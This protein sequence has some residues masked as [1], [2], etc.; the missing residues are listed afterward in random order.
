[1]VGTV[2]DMDMADELRVTLVATGLG[3]EV[4]MAQRPRVKLVEPEP[5]PQAAY[6]RLERPTV[7]RN[8]TD[9]SRAAVGNGD[10]DLDYLDIP[11]FLRKQAD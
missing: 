5:E 4:P 10:Y 11:A 7:L 1:V 9:Q 2:I 6:D 8:G 3:G